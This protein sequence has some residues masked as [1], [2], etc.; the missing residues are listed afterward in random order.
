MIIDLQTLLGASGL[1]LAL[2]GIVYSAGIQ[3]AR[4]V[5]LTRRIACAE[6][7]A[8]PVSPALAE[9]KARLTSIDQRLERMEA[10]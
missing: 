3:A 1:F 9:I 8:R 2:A 7:D 4:L 10:R 5:E 6:S